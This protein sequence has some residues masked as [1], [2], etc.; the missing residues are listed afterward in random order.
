[1]NGTRYIP[2]ITYVFW[3]NSRS[4]EGYWLVTEIKRGCRPVPLPNSRASSN[5]K[6]QARELDI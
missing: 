6:Q 4:G 5:R 3:K 2:V 1:M